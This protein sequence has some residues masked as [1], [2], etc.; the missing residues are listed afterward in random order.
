MSLKISG[1]KRYFFPEIVVATLIPYLI[2]VY[3]CCWDLMQLIEKISS[4]KF[5]IFK[6]VT[7]SQKVA[8]GEDMCNIQAYI[9]DITRK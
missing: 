2:L 7:G 5:S 3:S 1:K 4:S 9:S 8:C 6:A